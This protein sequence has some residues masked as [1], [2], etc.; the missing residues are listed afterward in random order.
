MTVE[1]FKV[2]ASKQGG[3]GSSMDLLMDSPSDD[4]IIPSDTA[5]LYSGEQGLRLKGVVSMATGEEAV[6]LRQFKAWAS[7]RADDVAFSH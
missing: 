6:T 2:W 7:K 4:L 5:A 1:Q 3:G